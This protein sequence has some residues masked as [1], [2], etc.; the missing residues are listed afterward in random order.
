MF[1]NY[2]GVDINGVNAVS[3]GEHGVFVRL[4]ASSTTLGAATSS[5]GAT[6]GNV[7][8][9]NT[10]DGIRIETASTSG[11]LVQGNLIG[12]RAGGTACPTQLRRRDRRSRRNRHDDRR[13]D[14][15]HRGT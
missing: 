1:G 3:N 2:L 14:G 5:P 8:S 7:I 6:G 9:G 12:L 15:D 11:T 13:H 4:G 10:V